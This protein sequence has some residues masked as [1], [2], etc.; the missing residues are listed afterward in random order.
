MQVPLN[1]PT[2]YTGGQLLFASECGGLEVR[3]IPDR[4]CH[5]GVHDPERMIIVGVG[6]GFAGAV[7]ECRAGSGGGTN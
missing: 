7:H 2:E 5:L 6:C 1:S 3:P 4:K